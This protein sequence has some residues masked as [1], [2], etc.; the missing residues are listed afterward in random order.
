MRNAGIAEGLCT[1]KALRHAFAV[2]AGQKD[3]P[4]NI[5]QRWLGHVR[6]ETIAIY[7][8]ALGDEE[9]KSAS[10]V[11][12]SLEETFSNIDAEGTRQIIQQRA[13]EPAVPTLE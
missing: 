9:R 10:R 4:L 7:A 1:P 8:S 6:F 3:V 2:D 11:W 13:R 5:V 12:D